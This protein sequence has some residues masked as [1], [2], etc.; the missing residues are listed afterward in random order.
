MGALCAFGE[1][2]QLLELRDG[3]RIRAEFAQGAVLVLQRKDI[4]SGELLEVL[5]RLEEVDRVSFSEE[6]AMEKLQVIQKALQCLESD[7]FSMREAGQTQL[8]A[9]GRGFRSILEQR[10]LV[11]NGAE[12]RWRLKHVLRLLPVEQLPEMRL[13]YD[14]VRTKDG[15][16]FEGDFGD[17]SLEVMYRGEALILS[18]QVVLGIR[19]EMAAGSNPGPAN[20]RRILTPSDDVFV[21]S[22]TIDFEADPAGA[23]PDVGED[24][25]MRFSDWGVTMQTSIPGQFVSV[26]DYEVAS[27]SR[28]RSAATHDPLYEGTMTIRFCVPGNPGIPAGVNSVGVW[29]AIVQKDGTALRAYDI[30][31]NLIDEVNAL[32]GPSEFFGITSAVP[33][34]EV[35]LVPNVAVDANY[36]ID[37]LVFSEPSALDSVGVVKNS[38]VRLRNGDRLICSKISDDGKDAFQCELASVPESVI[39]VQRGDLMA[40]HAPLLTRAKEVIKG[41][42]WAELVE[43]CRVLVSSENGRHLCRFP[44]LRMDDLPLVSLWGPSR[45]QMLPPWDVKVSEGEALVVDGDSVRR[46]NYMAFGEKWIN[47]E[48]VYRYDESPP[49][50]F[51]KPERDRDWGAS[52]TCTSGEVIPLGG[53]LGFRLDLFA[54]KGAVVSKGSQRWEIPFG[55]I[56]EIR[57][58]EP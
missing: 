40:M 12:V 20:A 42:F 6:P 18:R 32:S 44:E 25:G 34:H 4:V 43:G 22:R 8:L 33:I 47:D 39:R 26:N 50:W 45:M 52:I 49:V 53:T 13:P 2:P 1:T 7:D 38:A 16:V 3:T 48:D 51:A 9:G 31:G 27:V 55:E 30:R 36:T 5:V 41:V 28:G 37:D 11:G 56:A 24:I 58:D 15:R 14:I 29:M 19:D 46:I 57:F 10:L 23:R 17:W 21:G 35:R 54:V